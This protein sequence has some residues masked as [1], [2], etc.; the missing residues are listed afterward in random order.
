MA[1]NYTQFSEQI[2]NL[3]SEEEAWVREELAPTCELSEEEFEVWRD[4]HPQ[5]DQWPED[6]PTFNYELHSKRGWSQ[7]QQK[8]VAHPDK[9][10]DLWIYSEE[11]GSIEDIGEFVHA[12]LKKFRPDQCFTLTWADTCSK[13]RIGE[14]GGGAVFV[15]A[16]DIEWMNTYQWVAEMRSAFADETKTVE[17]DGYGLCVS[18]GH[19][20]CCCS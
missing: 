2:D 3:T 19:E 8:M 12:F 7:E 18:C 13:P 6:W 4:T 1:N 15:T 5:Y 14:F 20:R 16:D 17:R 11:Y 10:K 9:P